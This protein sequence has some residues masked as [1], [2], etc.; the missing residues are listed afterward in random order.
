LLTKSIA[1]EEKMT[2]FANLEQRMART[3]I[4]MFPKFAADKNAE[5]DTAEQE[6]FYF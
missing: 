4:D 6:K 1:G 3:Y 2:A 5:I